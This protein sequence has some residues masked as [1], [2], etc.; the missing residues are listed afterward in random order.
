VGWD[1]YAN[2]STDDGLTW[3]PSDTRLDTGDAPGASS[4]DL[5]DL[6]CIGR[7][8]FAVWEDARN[9]LSDVYYNS[10]TDNGA[11]WQGDQRIDADF[12]AGGHNS[13]SPRISV[14][15]GYVYI[16]YEDD[17]HGYSDVYF[18]YSL[19]YGASW[20]PRDIRLDTGDFAGAYGSVSPRITSDGTN[21]YA[22]WIDGRNGISDIYFNSSVN[23]GISWRDGPDDGDIM[24]TRSDDGGATWNPPVRVNNDVTNRG[25]FQPWIDVKPDGTIDV[26]WYDRRNDGNDSWLDVYIGTSRNRGQSFINSRVS[27]V[28]FGPPPAPTVWPWPWMGEYMGIDV[29]STYAYIAWTDTRLNDLDIYFDRFENPTSTGVSSRP[30]VPRE[31]YLSQNFP[32][33]FNPSTTI[34][35]GLSTGGHVSLR[36][37]DVSGKLVRIVSEG[38]RPAGHY[39]VVWDGKDKNGE[40]VASGLYFSR[41]I[42][43][44]FSQTRKM[45]LLK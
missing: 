14:Q 26:V 21:V 35:F 20:Y 43:T 19:N 7:R 4:S 23:N 24:L 3:Q 37:Y 17:R 33:P 36:I 40:P 5:V 28:N 29:D 42:A 31:D 16:A 38:Q 11:T 41:L 25:Q 9:G 12:I 30:A 39:E 22:L 27:D 44:G 18:R 10:S 6:A 34:A 13:T 2:Y 8:V 45:V 32:N 15:Q 1:I